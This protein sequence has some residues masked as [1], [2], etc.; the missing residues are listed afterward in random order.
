[1]D[2]L[3]LEIYEQPRVRVRSRTRLARKMHAKKGTH[4]FFS[5]MPYL[6]QL[7]LIALAAFASNGATRGSG[8][9]HLRLERPIARDWSLSKVEEL[10]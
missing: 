5:V 9:L 7:L 1:M 2:H 10:Q 8:C 3:R 4:S 6:K